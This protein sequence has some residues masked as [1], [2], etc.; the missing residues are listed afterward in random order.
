MEV[1][2]GVA[3]ADFLESID[4]GVEGLGFGAS[5]TTSSAAD[6]EFSFSSSSASSLNHCRT[7]AS[8]RRSPKSM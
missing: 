6:P 7:S 3:F 1:L 4:F 2:S 5:F 8:S